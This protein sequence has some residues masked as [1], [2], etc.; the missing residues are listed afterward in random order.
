MKNLNF[1]KNQKGYILEK[2]KIESLKYSDYLRE[3][4]AD[5]TTTSRGVEPRLYVEGNTVMTW[6]VN[7]KVYEYCKNKTEAK[8]LLYSIWESNVSDNW[9]A[10]RFFTTKKDLFE[11][12]ADAQGREVKIIKRYFR[13]KD[14]QY[15][16]FLIRKTAF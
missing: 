10:P 14:A 7:H 5:E 15:K 6:G 1:K 4:G 3:Y 16:V 12:I 9:Y 11:G 2:R 8:K 13:I